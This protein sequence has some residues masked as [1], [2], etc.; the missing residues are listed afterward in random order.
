MFLRS[1]PTAG[2]IARFLDASRDLPL[3]YA[4]TGLAVHGGAGFALDEQVTAIGTGDAAFRRAVDGVLAW[5]QFDLGW[6]ELFPRPAPA[7]PGTVVAVLVRHYGFW[8]L[9]GCRVVYASGAY[10]GPEFGVAYGT[11][12]NHGECGEE[13]FTVGLDA[14]TGQVTYTIR[15]ASKPQSPLAA[16][17][18]RRCAGSS[19]GF[20]GTRPRR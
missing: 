19:G 10:Q 2:V 6:V 3:S 13:L 14:R 11:L 18:T 1:R 4:P 16:I 9:N 17:G 8:S 5:R 20:A 12:P 7:V 15:A